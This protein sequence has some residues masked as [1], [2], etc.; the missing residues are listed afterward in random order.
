ML[1]DKLVNQY[2]QRKDILTPDQEIYR[3]HITNLFHWMVKGDDIKNDKVQE[4]ITDDFGS[5]SILSKQNGIAAGLEEITYLLKTQTHLSVGTRLSDGNIMQN[6]DVIAEIKGKYREIL[7]YERTILNILGRMSGIATATH[8][9]GSQLQII[10]HSPLI[11]A[12]RKTP[13][14]FLDKKAVAVGG[15]L[16][17]RLHL[18]DWPLI[19]D[20]H[21]VIL[22]KELQLPLQ[23]NVIQEAV[24][25]IIQTGVPFFELEVENQ[26]EAI[27]AIETFEH[28]FNKNKPIS[29][30]IMLDNFVPE[31]AHQC[32]AVLQKSSTYSFVLVEASGGIAKEN[33]LSW[34]KTSVDII[35]SGNIT[36]SSPS[37]NF[38]MEI[39]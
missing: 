18:G 2:F 24:K 36:H 35:S 8:K 16:T 19:K 29:M 3:D 9:L 21:L 14:L 33:I 10:P 6:G 26:D 37:Y 12:T 1:R 32:V 7:S 38:S 31:S 15:G 25:R 28:L 5:A 23:K 17:H 11:A 39:M 4:I 27:A 22:K 30:A 13:L 20:N 34:A